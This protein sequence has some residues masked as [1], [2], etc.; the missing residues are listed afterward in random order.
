MKKKDVTLAPEQLLLIWENHVKF[1]S[2]RLDKQSVWG[3]YNEQLSTAKTVGL[4]DDL[5]EICIHYLHLALWGRPVRT[6]YF[7]RGK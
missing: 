3:Y 6:S 4:Q 5:Y 7:G 2:K 1:I